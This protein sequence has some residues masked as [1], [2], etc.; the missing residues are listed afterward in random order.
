MARRNRIQNALLALGAVLVGLTIIEL[1]I[2]PLY[3]RV[4][5]TNLMS[6]NERFG[7]QLAQSSKANVIPRDYIMLT[8]D[9]YSVGLGDA[10]M[11][12]P[13]G[14]R[15]PY[16]SAHFIAERLGRDVLSIGS[17]GWS[18]V[19]S[20]LAPGLFAEQARMSL[21]YSIPPPS[22]ILYYF[23]E[24]NDLDDNLNW[25]RLSRKVDFAARLYST[26]EIETLLD[27]QRR[28]DAGLSPR[29]SR[30]AKA[31]LPATFFMVD[32]IH[33]LGKN[34]L[35]RLS[36]SKDA[37]SPAIRAAGD[38]NRAIVDGAP[39][40]LPD[41]LQAPA[42]ALSDVEWTNSVLTAKSALKAMGT[43]YRG[44]P[45]TVVYL[46]S[47]L[48]S[49]DIVSEEVSYQKSPGPHG[50]AG[51]APA[52]L[53][54]ERLAR[55]RRDVCEIARDLGY[56][57]IDATPAI[58]DTGRRMLVHG[59][60]DWTHFNLEGYRS[61]G[62]FVADR[63]ANGARQARPEICMP[64]RPP[65]RF[66]RIRGRGRPGTCCPASRTRTRQRSTTTRTAPSPRSRRRASAP[67]TASSATP[68]PSARASAP[69]RRPA[70]SR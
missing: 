42:L 47:P 37:E 34:V 24:G 69:T 2:F 22:A 58:R 30:F 29:L 1:G 12:A 21:R 9:S 17:G 44:V 61:L 41:R 27:A 20:A 56:G 59:P 45:I 5:P 14:S 11:L 3:L 25:A 66:D 60:H 6:L 19:T 67:S 65:P 33:K 57:F 31:N 52:K 63:L 53:A 15:E 39:L 8:G 7:Q 40:N 64:V 36:G 48:S 16:A 32:A 50:E 35:R 4:M 38:V 51:V 13:A 54:V 28:S 55:L 10:L 23:Y 49:Y 43:A 62:N 68:R 70:W 26:A 46:P 18:S